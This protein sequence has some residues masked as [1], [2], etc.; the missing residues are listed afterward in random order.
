[1]VQGK[2]KRK[3]T[4][5]LIIRREMRDGTFSPPERLE[6]FFQLFLG[7]ITL[8]KIPSENG[9]RLSTSSN[10]AF[11]PIVIIFHEHLI[12]LGAWHLIH[13][14]ESKGDDIESMHKLF[15]ST[16]AEIVTE[17]LCSITLSSRL[18][19]IL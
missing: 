8:N 16:F 13:L 5:R 17:L 1:M 12:E 18:L 10:S 6:M 14:L 3:G 19:Q 11:P 2:Y 7:G 9:S 4:Q 15:K